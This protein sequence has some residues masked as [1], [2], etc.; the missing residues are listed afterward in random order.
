MF[1]DVSE[2]GN[3]ALEVP[4]ERALERVLPAF[5]IDHPDSLDDSARTNVAI[6]SPVP[7]D[8][9]AFPSC[10]PK[11]LLGASFQSRGWTRSGL[12]G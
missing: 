8:G 10:G 1:G 4:Q 7:K 6:Y 9:S 2:S 3:D 5:M 12:T 11:G